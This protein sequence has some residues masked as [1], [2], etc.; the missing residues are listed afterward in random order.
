MFCLVILYVSV[1]ILVAR[2]HTRTPQLQ[3]SFDETDYDAKL[4]R[5]RNEVLQSKQKTSRKYIKD[6]SEQDEPKGREKNKLAVLGGIG[7]VNADIALPKKNKVSDRAKANPYRIHHL[8]NQYQDAI[9]HEASVVI[10][11]DTADLPLAEKDDSN[12]EKHPTPE[13]ILT[14]Y[15]EMVDFTEWEVKPLPPRANAR[16]EKLNK[17]QYPRLRS[18]SKLT[19]QFPIDDTPSNEDPFLPWIHDVFPTADGK[20]IQFVAQNK[21]RC[22]T[23]RREQDIVMF[24]QPQ[25]ALFQH[26]PV[27]R[28]DGHYKI[29][30]YADADF[31]GITTRFICRFKPSGEE[32]LS[33][34]NLDYD[35][36][37]LRKRYKVTFEK[38]GDGGVKSI[39]TSQLVFQCPVPNQLQETVRTGASV[40]D[41]WATLFLDIVPIRTPPRYGHPGQYL[42]PWYQ[43]SF[44]DV[45]VTFDPVAEWGKDGH[46]LPLMEESGRWENIPICKPSL[47]TYTGQEEKDLPKVDEPIPKQHRLVSCI[48]ASAG[49]ATR[50]NRF[51]IND[52]QRRL[53]EWVSHNKLIGFDHTYVYDNTGAFR[54]DTSLRIIANLFPD[55]ITYIPW[56]AQVCELVASHITFCCEKG[57]D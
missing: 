29:V 23:G 37:A 38:E 16:K 36:T 19:Q 30:D 49:Y 25:A 9:G 48:W 33:V 57:R 6:R 3:P 8:E 35:W 15:K 41:D 1:V 34:L 18:C 14:A 32:T 5:A 31:D 20:Y 22:K 43:Q 27:K 52:G 46:V 50:G 11:D 7:I 55:D 45:A 56:P 54:N 28:H 4:K 47:M 12:P 2:T 24:M 13:Y 44:H 10:K 42:A 40:K 51:A 39:H 26:V 17:V 21:R 53:V